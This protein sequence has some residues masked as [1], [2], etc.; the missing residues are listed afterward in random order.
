MT[1]VRPRKAAGATRARAR[2]VQRAEVVFVASLFDDDA[3]F[4]QEGLSVASISRREHAVEHVDPRSDA[5]DEIARR[6][7]AHQIARPG[8]VEAPRD[9]RE[10]L[11]HR[12]DRLS[13][14]ESPQREP[15]EAAPLR[16]EGAELLGMRDAQVFVR[17]ALNDAEQRLIGPFR[18]EAARGPPRRRRAGLHHLVTRR[19]SGW[20]DVELHRDVRADEP[21]DPHRLLGRQVVARAVEVRVEREAVFGRLAQLGQGERLKPAGVGEHRV[22]PLGEAVKAPVRRHLLRAGAEPEVVGVSEH[23]ARSG[24]R[25]LLRRERLDRPLCP[26]R[27]EGGGLDHA[28]RRDE[29]AAAC[30]AVA[31][32]DTEAEPWRAGGLRAIDR[33]GR[34][35][36]RHVSSA[37]A[38]RRISIA[39]P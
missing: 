3:A 19:L 37:L 34:Q 21:L 17:A 28:V 18:G 9:P 12:G 31:R 38:R 30:R 4:A 35:L 29:R 2:L 15:I 20:T 5:D 23:D 32:E 39:S 10:H 1:Q 14:R 24:R 8:F 27:H 11:V 25:D 33:R 26:D 22:R 36:A 6:P 13:D 7:D 16:G